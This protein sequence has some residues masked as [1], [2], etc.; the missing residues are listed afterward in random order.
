MYETKHIQ[1]RARQR[2]VT[3]EM[4]DLTLRYGE[5]RGDKIRLGKKQIQELISTNKELKSKLLKIMDKG[6][7]VVV[8]SKRTL[9]TVYLWK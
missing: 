1:K 2:G 5:R 8:V 7:L 4:I 6:G 3:N 9:I